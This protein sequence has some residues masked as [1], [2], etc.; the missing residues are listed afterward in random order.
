MRFKQDLDKLNHEKAL[1][2]SFDEN[3][4]ITRDTMKVL[5]M[6]PEGLNK[7]MMTSP[8][9][10]KY[11]DPQNGILGPFLKNAH[12][13]QHKNLMGSLS[14]SIDA[15]ASAHK[16]K[17]PKMIPKQRQWDHPLYNDDKGGL[18]RSD[19]DGILGLF[20]I[21]NKRAKGQQIHTNQVAIDNL[22]LRKNKVN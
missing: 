10:S 3:L 4:P 9:Q 12:Y 11:A 6:T 16:D 7:F 17:L 2:R 20:D 22:H 13:E 8:K 21:N 19:S 1:E 15:H 18:K 5:N 14:N